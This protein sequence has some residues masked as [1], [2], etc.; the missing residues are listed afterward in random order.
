MLFQVLPACLV[1]G[2]EDVLK[3]PGCMSPRCILKGGI[4]KASTESSLLSHLLFY[5]SSYR[6]NGYTAD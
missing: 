4:P 3:S 5:P 6:P 1:A 2:F